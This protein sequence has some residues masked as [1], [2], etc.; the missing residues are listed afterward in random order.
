MFSRSSDSLDGTERPWR[1]VLWIT[2]L[3]VFQ[4]ASQLAST[5]LGEGMDSYGHWAYIAFFARENRPPNPAEFSIPADI[6]QLSETRQPASRRQDTYRQWSQFSPNE[7]SAI[8]AWILPAAS[9]AP[10][11]ALNTQAQHAPLYY[12][13][14]S[15]PYRLLRN[16][17]LDQQAFALGFLSILL[18]SAAFPAF[19]L[20]L[21]RFLRADLA[22]ILTACIAW[23]P[24]LMSYLGRITN[25]ALAFPLFAWL[26]YF[27]SCEDGRMKRHLG[28]GLALT[29]GIMTKSYFLTAVP[30][31]FLAAA[32][33][34]SPGETS[35]A[36]AVARAVALCALVLL[37]PV[38]VNYL[39]SGHFVPMR[40][41][42]RT[43]AVP[44]ATK[45]AEMLHV[46]PLWFFSGLAKGF[47]WSGYWSFVSPGAL[48]YIPLLAI[49][50]LFAWR[51]FKRPSLVATSEFR[52]LAV[53][54]GMIFCF[55]AGL[56]VYAGLYRVDAL[57]QGRA[58]TQGN[59]GW[60]LDVLF[61][62]I[63][64]ILAAWMTR[65]FSA[66]TAAR[67]LKMALAVMCFWNLWARLAL[68]A[69]WSG[70]AE[71]VGRLRS[72]S[73]AAMIQA[74]RMP[75]AWDNWRSLPG[76]MEP[77]ALT[78]LVPAALAIGMTLMLAFRNRT[79][80]S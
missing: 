8:L 41:F 76:V 53:H 6:A 79:A 74:L 72:V 60:Y 42:V 54:Y 61:G 11:T 66:R 48:F 24:N 9:E 58:P 19:Y 56:W 43:A 36:K 10:Y 68:I 17:P 25:D 51:L 70:A 57:S 3:F 16:L 7:R 35:R 50:L 67:T 75:E 5:P 1:A 46:N 31:F 23:Y 20:I 4:M 39:Y 45:F 38:L 30:V 2:I 29:F 80:A 55:L 21:R 14:M 47:F 78:V 34:P 65:C 52:D 63:A 22:L 37:L 13:A 33:L 28:A 44:L 59:E 71:P 69:F 32:V 64:A 27:L 18:A 12:A 77:I 73:P 15:V 26:A 49:P 40:Q 62:S